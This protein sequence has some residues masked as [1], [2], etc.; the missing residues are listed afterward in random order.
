MDRRSLG[1]CGMMDDGFRCSDSMCD[2]HSLPSQSCD[3]PYPWTDDD[4]FTEPDIDPPNDYDDDAAA[5]R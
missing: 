2:G 5:H 1:S 4:G 3:D